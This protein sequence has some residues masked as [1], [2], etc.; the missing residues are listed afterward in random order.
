DGIRDFHVTGVQTCALPISAGLAVLVDGR[1]ETRKAAGK[2]AELE[3]MLSNGGQPVGTCGIAHTRWATH[4][5][6]TTRNAHPHVDCNGQIAVVHN[7]IIE[8]AGTLRQKLEALGHTLRTET[9]TE[10]IAH[11]LEEAYGGS[12]EDAVRV[13]LR[14][15][16]GTYG[17][18]VVSSHEP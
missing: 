16:E 8:N 4:G 12:L 10:V 15:V 17:I 18:A 13:A 3:K 9:D 7:G 1:L 6:P 5:A 14:Q 11:M 2:I